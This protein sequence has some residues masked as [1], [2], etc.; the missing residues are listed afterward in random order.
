MPPAGGSSPDPEP[1]PDQ[2]GPRY[3][4][5]LARRTTWRPAVLPNSERVRGRSRRIR[6]AG[7]AKDDPLPRRRTRP[8]TGHYPHA[9]TFSTFSPEDL[10]PAAAGEAEQQA[11]KAAV[12]A[13]GGRSW[14]A[15]NGTK[16]SDRRRLPTEPLLTFMAATGKQLRGKEP[17]ARP[18]VRPHADVSE[19]MPSKENQPAIS[20][21]VKER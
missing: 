21:F 7:H 3:P 4:A 1:S 11:A 20:L 17:Q 16:V 12:G 18:S 14:A 10:S 5:T 9:G 15:G 19:C 2:Q 13:A 8:R 6:N